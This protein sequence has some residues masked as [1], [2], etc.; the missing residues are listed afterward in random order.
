MQIALVRQRYNPYGGAERF[1]ERAVAAL[2][3][4]RI[5]VTLI[6][7]AWQGPKERRVLVCNPFYFGRL[8]R[9]WGFARAV[10]RLTAADRFDL[11][12]S[13]ERIPGCGLYRAGDGVHAEWLRQRARAMGVAG[14]IGVALNPYHCYVLRAERALFRSPQLRAVICISEMVKREVID[15]FEVAEDKLHVLY[16]G[17][18]SDV[19]HPRL[20]QTHRA[21]MRA[22]LGWS[23]GD[24]VFLLVGSGFERKG[25]AQL[26]QAL[27][28]LPA[29]VRLLIVGHDKLLDR[30]RRQARALGI[31]PRVY[32]AGGQRDVLPYYGAADVFAMPT[33]YE[34]FG[35]VILE[36]LACGLPVVTSTKCGGGELIENGREGF[37]VDAL[38]VSALAQALAALCDDDRRKRCAAA[39]RQRAQGFTLDH[40]AGE[41][42]ALYRQ[43]LS[44][45]QVE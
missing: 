2:A 9:D 44:A 25:V 1:V 42:T 21:L 29:R 28:A 13:H 39:A 40:M 3:D 26:L 27:R 11:V 38:D 8:W 19:F 35:N 36:A 14:R 43:L 32:F 7:R 4:Q 15:H 33:L 18:D 45:A 12:Q 22:K 23:E 37:V 34:P 41:F 6:T 17:I 24:V 31:E 16:N 20:R 10:Q 30:Y 5:A